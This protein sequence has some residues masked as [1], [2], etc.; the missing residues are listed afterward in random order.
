MVKQLANGWQRFISQLPTHPICRV[1]TVLL[2]LF[3]MPIKLIRQK[4]RRPK[5]IFEKF[6]FGS[7]EGL[8]NREISDGFGAN[9]DAIITEICQIGYNSAIAKYGFD[10]LMDLFKKK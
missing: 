1:L 2:N 9:A 5:K 7:A 3:S 4:S 10:N 6:F 8:S